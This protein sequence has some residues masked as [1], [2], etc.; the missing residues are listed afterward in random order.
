[1]SSFWK[2]FRSLDEEN[3]IDSLNQRIQNLINRV[4]ILLEE[5]T[6]LHQENTKLHQENSD[7]KV[8]VAKSPSSRPSTLVDVPANYTDFS[9]L[10]KS[11]PFKH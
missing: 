6:K 1:M 2:Q 10:N 5:N 7:L 3:I 8:I 4:R 11:N 9:F